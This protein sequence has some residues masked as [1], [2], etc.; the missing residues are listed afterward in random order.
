ME[1]ENRYTSKYPL[2]ESPGENL[3]K[4]R[5]SGMEPFLECE[6]EQWA[7]KECGHIVSVHTGICSGCGKQYGAQVIQVN[8]D[9]WRISTKSGRPT[10]TFRSVPTASGSFMTERKRS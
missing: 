6:R 9:T 10:R 2:Y 8:E 4:I 7:C 5:E 1:N 3:R